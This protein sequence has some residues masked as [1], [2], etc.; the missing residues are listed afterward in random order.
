MNGARYVARSVIDTSPSH[1]D[2]AFRYRPFWTH[3]ADKAAAC[4]CSAIR[5][6]VIQHRPKQSS[7]SSHRHFGLFEDLTHASHIR[8]MHSVL[9]EFSWGILPPD[10]RR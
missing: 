6:M 10:N 1:I 5:L 3:F 9:I 4:R 2:C 7:S 8:S